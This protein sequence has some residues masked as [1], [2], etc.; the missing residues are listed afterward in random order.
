MNCASAA[1]CVV[2]ERMVPGV[3]AVRQKSLFGHYSQIVSVVSMPNVFPYIGYF[4]LIA[5]SDIFVIYD[6]AQY[7]KQVDK[8][9]PM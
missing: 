9:H 3:S 8:S 2:D 1:A 7:V 6:G 4:Q 5:V